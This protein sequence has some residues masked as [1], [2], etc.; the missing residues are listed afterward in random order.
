MSPA[1][2]LLMVIIIFH[3]NNS[4][5]IDY[6]LTVHIYNILTVLR[7]FRVGYRVIHSYNGG[8]VEWGI[9]DTGGLLSVAM[10]F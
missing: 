8:S 4:F 7:M 3:E 5:M 2:E 9:E 6:S 1:G 10:H